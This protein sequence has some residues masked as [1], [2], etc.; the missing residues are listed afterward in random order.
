[1]V[2]VR[3]VAARLHR[4]AIPLRDGFATAAGTHARRE[5]LIIELV[6]DA[7]RTGLG[8]ASPLP[9]LSA[10]SLAA[11]ETAAR[12]RC[13]ALVGQELDAD[14]DAIRAAL[15]APH[16]G[17]A[18]TRC[19]LETALADLAARAADLPLARFL[20]PAAA[21]TVPCNAVL[22]ADAMVCPP[23]Y[24]IVKVKVGALDPA[25]DRRRLETLFAATPPPVRFRLDANRAWTPRQALAVLS[26]L[27][28]DRIEY[29]EEPLAATHLDDLDEV[30]RRCGLLF[31]LD[32]TLADPRRWAE[33]LRSGSVGAV[34][35]KPTLLG[36]LSPALALAAAARA[37]NKQVVVTSTLETG[38]GVTAC[39]HLAAAVATA[40]CGLDTLRLLD[41]TL[42]DEAPRIEG[43]VMG[44]PTEPGLGVTL[45]RRGLDT[46]AEFGG[47]SDG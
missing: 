41:G 29:V 10:E 33:W 47:G 45:D 2:A 12:E 27:P 21:T 26:G 24:G 46:V 17:P 5:G 11:A 7:G 13:G 37:A 1:M 32:E 18:A 42:L 31:A 36:G 35:L 43:G 25:A 15:P 44:M 4:F 38:V 14:L 30:H 39:L 9:G 28:A 20:D 34:I 16:E 8:E 3:I 22:P 6:D 19:A 40:P 23:G